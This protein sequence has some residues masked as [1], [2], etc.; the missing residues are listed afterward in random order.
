MVDPE[1][2]KLILR[3]AAPTNRKTSNYRIRKFID[4]MLEDKFTEDSVLMFDKH[5]KLINGQHRLQ[6]LI[7]LNQVIGFI[8]VKKLSD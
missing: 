6:A 4:L 3:N 1:L 8:I 5:D 2:A 7:K